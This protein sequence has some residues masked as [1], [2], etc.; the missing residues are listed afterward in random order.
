MTTEGLATPGSEVWARPR[1]EIR[2]ADRCDACSASAMERWENGR[3]EFLLCK[4][5]ANHHRGALTAAGWVLTE[6]WRFELTTR[7]VVSQV[8]TKGAYGV[9][10]KTKETEYIR[11]LSR[12]REV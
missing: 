3:S 7:E 9:V 8:E 5:H 11:G 1:P 12:V 10:N 6:S 2:Q 4:H